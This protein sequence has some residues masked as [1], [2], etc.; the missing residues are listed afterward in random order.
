[1]L[2][3]SDIPGG[4]GG[5]CESR[6]PLD[7]PHGTVVLVHHEK[8]RIW[9]GKHENFTYFT[10]KDM[11][12]TNASWKWA[13]KIGDTPIYGKFDWENE[14]LNQGISGYV[15]FFQ[16]QGTCGSWSFFIR[17]S[18][19][20]GTMGYTDFDLLTLYNIYIYIHMYIYIIYI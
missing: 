18:S 5:I 15:Y 19:F 10:L 12:F 11:D 13:L 8:G 4:P 3:S 17:I 20:W 14:F 16:T 1:M 7:E 6:C 9:G 2:N